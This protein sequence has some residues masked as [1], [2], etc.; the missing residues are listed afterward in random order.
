MPSYSM[1]QTFDHLFAEQPPRL[2]LVRKADADLLD[3]PRVLHNHD[4]RVE[5][6]YIYSGH[7]RHIIAGKTYEIEPGDLVVYNAGTLH[8]EYIDATPD[9]LVYQLEFQ[10]VNITGLD[11]NHLFAPQL[12]PVIKPGERRHLVESLILYIYDI[13]ATESTKAGL[14]AVRSLSQALLAM[15][16]EMAAKRS[17]PVLLQPV[18]ERELLSNGRRIKQWLDE[19]YLEP[20]A[21]ED[22][23]KALHLSPYHLSH[24]FKAYSGYSP[25]QYINRRRIGEAQS[26]LV[27]TGQSITDIALSVGF[28]S[29]S[30]FSRAFTQ[31]VGRSPARY[32]KD[33]QKQT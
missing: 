13:L 9:M 23:A 27:D 12:P 17:D 5:V 21:L 31:A 15:V 33:Y 2:T 6:I 11:P 32:R 26:M 7:S 18:D 28:S 19:H 14:E 4:D 25:I 20:L 24:V 3:M 29:S 8:E 22:I 10:E 30:L 16:H 1:P